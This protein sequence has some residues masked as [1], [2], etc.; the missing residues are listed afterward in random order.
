MATK[1]ATQRASANDPELLA[2]IRGWCK[3]LDF[4][5][6]ITLRMI[7]AI[8]CTY[9]MNAIPNIVLEITLRML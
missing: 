1:T 7:H 3:E 2:V 9:D 8:I 5:L 6:E 4:V